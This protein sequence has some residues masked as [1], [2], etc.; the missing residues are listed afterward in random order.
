MWETFS[1]SLKECQAFR[2]KRQGLEVTNFLC[3]F[4]LF[5]VVLGFEPKASHLSAKHSTTELSLQP[6]KSLTWAAIFSHKG[7]SSPSKVGALGQRRTQAPFTHHKWIFSWPWTPSQGCWDT[8]GRSPL[9]K[10]HVLCQKQ[11]AWTIHSGAQL[12]AGSPCRMSALNDNTGVWESILFHGAVVVHC[13][14]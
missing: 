7:I 10:R 6:L 11:A 12:R 9:V 1:N 4:C 8:A 13:D 2:A 3:G 14:Y 5:F